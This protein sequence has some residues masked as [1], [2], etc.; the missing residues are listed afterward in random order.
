[1]YC[2]GYFM[3]R[4]EDGLG[5]GYGNYNLNLNSCFNSTGDSNSDPFNWSIIIPKRSFQKGEYEGLS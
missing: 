1:M 2:A 5:G 4:P 3:I